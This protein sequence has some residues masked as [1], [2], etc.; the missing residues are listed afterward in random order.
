L[1]ESGV[2]ALNV[3]FAGSTAEERLDNCEK[4]R[5]LVDTL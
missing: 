5:R 4:L 3:S 2:N 1:R